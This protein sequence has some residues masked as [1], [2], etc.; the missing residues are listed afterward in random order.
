MT[1][2]NEERHEIA[3]SLREHQ[4]SDVRYPT[5]EGGMIASWLRLKEALGTEGDDPQEDHT[6][7]FGY[8]ADLI[9]PEPERTCYNI[10]ESP[11]N[12]EFWPSPRFKCSEC[13]VSHVS[14]DYVYY[15]PKCGAKVVE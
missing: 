11:T 4:H 5:F 1:I 3:A 12:G 7:M 14:M 6:M 13:K 10:H 9:E 2:T 15:C 8:L